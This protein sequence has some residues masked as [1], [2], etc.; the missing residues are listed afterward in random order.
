MAKKSKVEE[1][2]V[3]SNEEVVTPTVDNNIADAT[4]PEAPEVVETTTVKEAPKAEKSKVSKADKEF[5]QLVDDVTNGKHGSGRE[6]MLSLG[7]NYSKV[8]TE[9]ARR[10]RVK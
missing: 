10:M 6:R 3:E 9:I 8:Q 5:N 7:S 2:K 4:P 1:T